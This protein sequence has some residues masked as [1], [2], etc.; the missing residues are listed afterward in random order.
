MTK[1][2]SYVRVST[3]V[4]VEGY[5]LDAQKDRIVNYA[6]FHNFNIIKEYADK[7]RSGKNI[8]NRPEFKQML[9]DIKD[10]KD[11]I[12]YVLVYKLSRFGRNT[13]DILNSLQFMQNYGV[14]L[15]AVEENINSSEGTGRLIISILSAVAEI[16]RENIHTFTMAGRIE[17]AKEGKWNGGIPPFGY[18][19]KNGKLEIDEESARIVRIIFDKYVNE[20]YGVNKIAIY[21]NS[22]GYTKPKRTKN[23]LSAFSYTFV[24]RVIDNP[25]Y[26]GKIAYGRT[27][28]KKVKG[29]NNETKRVNAGK[30]QLF[31][32]EH[33]PIV[34]ED[35]W[36]A[37]QKI[38]SLNN[39][40]QDKKF[41][42]DHEYILTGMLK[43]PEC[44][45][46]L[47]GNVNRKMKS[48]GTRYRDYY[49]YQCKNRNMVNGHKCSYRRSDKEELVNQAV[50][51]VISSLINNIQFK[52]ALTET[53]NLN[54]D[55]SYLNK[56]L[57][58][59][60]ESYR[61]NQR[62]Q[63]KLF[64]QIDSLDPLDEHYERKF[65]DIN[66]R[67]NKFYDLLVDIE[68]EI[69]RTRAK[70]VNAQKEQ[71]KAA[72]VY[73][74]LENF[75]INYDKFTDAEKKEVMSSFIER[76]EI[77]PKDERENGQ[78][79]KSITLKFPVLYK[80][81]YVNTISWDKYTN[82]ETIVLMS[83]V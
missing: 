7:G 52:K 27:A 17:K 38:R 6:K 35:V 68:I 39:Y 75:N 69:E 36:M 2:Y 24:T 42:K 67:A 70:I 4:Q 30:Y 72:E 20:R 12:D 43:C 55:I 23:E 37:A 81:K 73:S 31:E 77:Y 1:C 65:D 49:Y 61:L 22:Q 57:K 58:K 62:R 18:S 53:L 15:I 74:F 50:K 63:A 10:Q 56:E 21:L 40:R 32:G 80:N 8:K 47:Y 78:I 33:E 19:L 64:N 29:S 51:E 34:S 59:Y 79:I 45:F 26:M 13:V 46:N 82:V 60:Q 71:V 48:D 41:S 44:G 11:D 25:T 9:E 16:E 76:I 54:Q 3:E 28:R 83:R 5:S 14:N 66:D